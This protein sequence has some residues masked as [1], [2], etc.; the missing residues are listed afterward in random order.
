MKFGEIG[1][2]STYICFDIETSGLSFDND[3]VI[4]IGYSFIRDGELIQ[5]N[6]TLIKMPNNLKLSKNITRITGIS[7]YDLDTSGIEITEALDW[8][9]QIIDNAYP[10]VGHNIFRFDHPFLLR[11]AKRE[12][13]PIKDKLQLVRLID[14]AVI[15]K[16]LKMETPM[17]E[18]ELHMLYASRILDQPVKGLKY[19]LKIA[20]EDNQVK[21]DDVRAHRAAADVLVTYRLYEALRQ[22]THT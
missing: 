13:H 11:V 17:K 10:L 5:S 4:E 15:Y 18:G 22:K 3:H 6:S 8:F 16:G 19:N 9:S 1:L 7:N 2:P 21:T 12:D 20:C 14:T